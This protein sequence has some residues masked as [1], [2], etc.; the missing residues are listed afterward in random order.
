MAPR[1]N[2]DNMLPNNNNNRRL[3]NNNNNNRPPNN[4]ND[5]N[6]NDN[7]LPNNNN[8]NL[9]LYL[10]DYIINNYTEE[11]YREQTINMFEILN[12]RYGIQ[13]PDNLI[14][15]QDI[16]SYRDVLLLYTRQVPLFELVAI[17]I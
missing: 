14:Q 16:N 17:G 15:L 12:N 10:Q 5:N 2:N 3:N 1:L 4:N 11:M 8:M 6:N 7:R 13:H 9:E